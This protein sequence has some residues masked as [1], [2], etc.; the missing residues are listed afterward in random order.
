MKLKS[1]ILIILFLSCHNL[2]INSTVKIDG[3]MYSIDNSNH[4][5]TVEAH[6]APS[7]YYSGDIVIPE[8]FNYWIYEYTVTA[9]GKGA[10]RDSPTLT[11]VSIPESVVTIG[12]NAFQ[13]CSKLKHVSMKEGIESIGDHCFDNCKE[14]EVMVLPNS[15]ITIGKY[16]FFGCSKIVSFM[17]GSHVE[18]IGK[19]AFSY[20]SSLEAFYSFSEGV[21]EVDGDPWDPFLNAN[22]EIAVLY[23]PKPSITAYV[24]D[25]HWNKFLGIYA[26]PDELIERY[27]NNLSEITIENAPQIFDVSGQPIQKKKGINIIRYKDGTVKKVFVK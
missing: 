2:A 12:D 27:T 23:V 22:L 16:A 13:N 7:Y 11:S 9:I 14:L 8:K 24:N 5:A 21:P 1:F 19:A 20:L 6:P 26:I 10:F 3:I 15:V 4:T 25:E 18:K 17:I